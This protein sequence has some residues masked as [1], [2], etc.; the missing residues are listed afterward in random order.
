AT[1]DRSFGSERQDRRLTDEGTQ[2][3]VRVHPNLARVCGRFSRCV[4]PAGRRAGPCD[5]RRGQRRYRRRW[6]VEGKRRVDRGGHQKRPGCEEPKRAAAIARSPT[7]VIRVVHWPSAA[8][9][10]TTS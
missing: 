1:C 10:T 4:Q 8:S 3:R 2:I 7:H 9:W 6:E 5:G